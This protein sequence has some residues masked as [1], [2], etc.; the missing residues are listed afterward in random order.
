[1]EHQSA[2]PS[3]EELAAAAVT[4]TQL[5]VM[6]LVI[7]AVARRKTHGQ[8]RDLLEKVFECS[9]SVPLAQEWVWAARRELRRRLEEE[10]R[11]LRSESLGF[12]ESVIRDS[13]ASVGQKLS[14]QSRI[15]AVLG[16]EAR[17][18]RDPDEEVDHVIGERIR[19]FLFNAHG[20][21]LVEEESE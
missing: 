16:L 7:E 8:I 13:T 15:D 5:D 18:H 4:S 12:Y 9:V 2:L 1:M 3:A 19:K 11:D 14:A 17:S 20:L 10:G 21:G 6:E